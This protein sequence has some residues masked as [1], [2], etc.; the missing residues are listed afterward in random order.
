MAGIGGAIGAL[1]GS[2]GGGVNVATGVPG[3]TPEQ[4]ALA[5]FT[6]G[7][8]TTRTKDI[9]SRLGLGGSTM[10]AQDLGGNQLANMA[11]TAGIENQ[12]AQLQLQ[13]EQL[14]LASQA[15]ANQQSAAKGSAT[16]SAIGG[17]GSLFA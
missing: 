11:E 9:Y 14:Q 8:Q 3:L 2:G 16:G 5:D 13:Q 1:A 6:L 4:Q 7:E 12:N 17:L 15:Q 10:E